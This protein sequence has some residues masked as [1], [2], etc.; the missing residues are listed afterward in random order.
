[1]TG[2]PLP[3]AID[4]PYVVRARFAPGTI[5]LTIADA[6]GSVLAQLSLSTAETFERFGFVVGRDADGQ[7]TCLDDFL[8][9]DLDPVSP[10][11]ALSSLGLLLTVLL[12]IAVGRWALR[13]RVVARVETIPLT[14]GN[15]S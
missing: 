4:T 8:I 1:V 12:L 13:H 3:L 5:D 9:L 15:R 6:G 2:S 10:A 11:P 14:S 7:L